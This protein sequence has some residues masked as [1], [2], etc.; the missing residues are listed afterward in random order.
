MKNSGLKNRFPPEVKE[1]WL[2]HS[3]YTDMWDGKNDGDVLHHIKS[4]SS[5]DYVPGKH[6]TSVFNSCML[7][8]FRNHIGNGKLHD[9]DIEKQLIERVARR[10]VKSDYII[11]EIDGEFLKTYKII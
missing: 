5:W 4:P 7:N 2:V 11:K 8:N 10:I 1:W 3:P 9:P 6:N